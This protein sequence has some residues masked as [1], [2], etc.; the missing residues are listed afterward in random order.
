ML[1]GSRRNR[2]A[3]QVGTWPILVIAFAILALGVVVFTRLSTATKEAAE[4]Q[5][6]ADAAALAGAQAIG[7]DAPGQIVSALMS[8][9]T[10][11]ASL[12]QGPAQNFAS[13]NGSRVIHYTYNPVQDRVTVRVRS[14]AVTESGQREE[15][16]AVARLGL[17]L[18][19]C[20]HPPAPTPTP[21]PTT[22]PP[23]SPSPT[24]TTPPPPPPDVEVEGSC[25]DLEYEV[26]Y[27]GSGG[28]PQFHVDANL[29]KS[30]LDPRLV[31]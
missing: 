13:R 29:I 5:L 20:S 6:A 14:Q 10:L 9:G 8:G 15:A 16:T 4:I 27:P 31:S 22:T 18:G 25:G 11:P 2:E 12:G 21:T 19:P 1:V 17:R 28:P 30:L 3:G 7:Q 26:T 23:P 24:P